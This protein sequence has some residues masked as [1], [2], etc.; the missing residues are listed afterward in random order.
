MGLGKGK[1]LPHAIKDMVSG[2]IKQSSDALARATHCA[3]PYARSAHPEISVSVSGHQ[4]PSWSNRCDLRL[5]LIDIL[6]MCVFV[7]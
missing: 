2:L 6:E 5:I 4:L 7:D 1:F 3:E